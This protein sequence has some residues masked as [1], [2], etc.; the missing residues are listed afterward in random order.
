GQVVREEKCGILCDT[1]DPR[2]VA[3][4]IVFLL[5]NPQEAKTM[6]TRGR[7]AFEQKYN[8]NIEREKLL[9][10][11]QKLGMNTHE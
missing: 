10:L 7:K 9:R 5:K 3:D 8:W 2:E 4:A 6:G 11:Y 1:T